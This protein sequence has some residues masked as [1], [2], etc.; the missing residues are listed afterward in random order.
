[1]EAA[2]AEGKWPPELTVAVRA[3]KKLEFVRIAQERNLANAMASQKFSA[4]KSAVRARKAFA[5]TIQ[6]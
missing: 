3:A 6:G 5:V 1:M 2:L 4:I